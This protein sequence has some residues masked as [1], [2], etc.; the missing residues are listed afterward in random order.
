MLRWRKAGAGDDRAVEAAGAPEATR[1]DVPDWLR[2]DVPPATR[3]PRAL[4]PSLGARPAQYR[5]CPRA[6]ARPDRAPAAAGAARAAARAPRRGGAPASRAR[7]GVRRGAER[8]AIVREVL[9]VLDDARFAPLFAPGSRAEVPIVGIVS[10]AERRVSGQVDRLAVTA[11][12]VLIAD[13]KSDR[14]V[15]AP[16]RGHSRELYRRN[17]RST[18]QCCA[19][20]IRITACAPRWSGPPDRRSR[21]CP[22]RALDAA[23]SRLARSP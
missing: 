19:P 17:W 21:N 16:H 11:T 15:P 3:A 4:S 1:H 14:C 2:R 10:R 9:A 13:Y 18:G 6:R 22:T 12:D 8:D 7:E 23:M 5:R 20:S